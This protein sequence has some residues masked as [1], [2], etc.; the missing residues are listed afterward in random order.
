[1]KKILLSFIIAVFILFPAF[2]MAEDESDSDFLETDQV[3][4][5]D[6]GS[7][8]D[9]GTVD[10]VDKPTAVPTEVPTDEPTVAPTPKPTEKPAPKATAKPTPKKIVKKQPTPVPTPYPTAAPTPAGRQAEFS[11]VAASAEEIAKKRNFG[12][13]F[14]VLDRDRKFRMIFTLQ[15]TGEQPSFYTSASLL[16]GHTS[17]IIS[18][19]DKDKDLQTVLAGDKRELTFEILILGSYDGDARLPL[20]LKMKYSAME[21]DFPLDISVEP[22][23]PYLLYIIIGVGLLLLILII[24][25]IARRGGDSS[26]RKKDYDFEIK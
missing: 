25:L 21:K 7:L 11:I 19:K 26:R 23:S 18:D 10:K 5:H 24:I 20:T 3:N 16:S 15:N 22:E 14:G 9:S 8:L 2:S 1:M 4:K 13:Y 12:N 6:T 17:I